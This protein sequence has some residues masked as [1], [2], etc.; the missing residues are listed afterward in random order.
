MSTY[1]PPGT[2]PGPGSIGQRIDEAIELIEMEVRHAAAYIN[3]AVIPQ[4]RS[5]SITALRNISNS[6]RSF[7]DRLDTNQAQ[8][9]PSQPQPPTSPPTSGSGPGT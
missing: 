1:P 7:A 9:Q 3:S 2:G 6:L 8:N 5:E 4:V